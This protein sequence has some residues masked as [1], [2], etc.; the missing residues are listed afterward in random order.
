MC[1]TAHF[2]IG[3]RLGQEEHSKQIQTLSGNVLSDPWRRSRVKLAQVE[4][5]KSKASAGEGG[6]ARCSPQDQSVSDGVNGELVR[7][8]GLEDDEF[9]REIVGFV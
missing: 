3:G 4:A 2:R 6:A 5:K 7:L 9:F 8:L 1:F